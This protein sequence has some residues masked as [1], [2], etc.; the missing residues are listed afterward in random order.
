[1][2]GIAGIVN[3]R[4]NHKQL[5]AIQSMTDRIAHRGPDAEG[6][7]ADHRIAL[8]H[9]RLAIID[10]HESA[11]QPMWDHTGRYVLIYNGEIYNYKEVKSILKDYP[12]KTESDSEVILAAYATWGVRCLEKFNGMFAFAIWD[13][14][15]EVLFMARDR[16]GKKPCYYHHGID[17][18]VFSSEVR[19]MLASG[20]VPRQLDTDNLT[21]FFLYQAPMNDRSLVRDIRHLRA[22]HYVIIKEG[23]MTEHPYWGYDQVRPCN[24][25]LLQAKHKVRDL[26]LDAVRLRMV[27][28]VP[29][30]AFLSGGIDSSLIVACMAEQ[31]ESPINTFTISFDEQEYDESAY[32]QQIATLYKTN[33]H[34]ILIRPEEFLYSVDDILASL[35]TPSGDG[36]NS[37]LVAK[38]TRA[39]NIKVALSGLGGDE[40]FAGYNKF[41]I[42]QKIMKY[43]W[44]LNIPKSVRQSLAKTITKFGPGHTSAKLDSLAG[45]E[46][47]DLPSVYPLLRRAYGYDEINKLLIT[48]N[49]VDSVQQKL[50]TINRKVAWMGDFSKCTIGEMETYTRDVLLRDT[51]Q[52]SMV[53]ALEVRVP[54]F[55]YRLIEY[56]LSLPDYIK[57]P[58]TPKQ[59]LVDA[60]APRLSKELSQRKKMGFTFPMKHWLKNELVTMVDDK[61]AYLAERKEFNSDEV[62]SKW[63]AFKNGDQ[64]ILWTR[65]WKLVV[66][67]DWLQRNDL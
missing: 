35:D 65:I 52:M 59:L 66:L 38:Y 32:A 6:I 62:L 31:S 3:L 40:L 42:Y 48:P 7:Y 22:G 60:M 12:F 33:H 10:L 64:R 45:L 46:K 25:N 20:L 24:D 26:L 8:G 50:E 15:E 47:W 61:I 28:D 27:S 37:Y 16:V 5:T 57:F 13:A 44:M 54:F 9:R 55:D 39:A 1:M 29:V 2:C 17:H 51:D 11:N 56:L 23:T 4:D 41:M 53:H 63:K 58:H 49:H 67:S 34:R 14:K 36:P 21:E 30:G 43:S 19:S 18:F